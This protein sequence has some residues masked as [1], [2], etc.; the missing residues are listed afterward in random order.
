VLIF[1]RTI[2]FGVS[3]YKQKTFGKN[4]SDEKTEV[5]KIEDNHLNNSHFYHGITKVKKERGLVS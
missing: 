2:E 1:D 3:E 4:Y 5:H